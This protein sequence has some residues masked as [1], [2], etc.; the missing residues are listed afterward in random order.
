MI[1]I[2]ME[3]SFSQNFRKQFEEIQDEL[4]KDFFLIFNYIQNE[5]AKEGENTF[6]NIK[7]KYTYFPGDRILFKGTEY[8]FQKESRII[9]FYK[10]NE[11]KSL[12]KIESHFI[13]NPDY[14]KLILDKKE[15]INFIVISENTN[16]D[17]S[18]VS[19]DDYSS[20][21]YDEKVK[22]ILIYSISNILT[23]E[24][25]NKK[26][27]KNFTFDEIKIRDLSLNAKKYF[28]S[29]YQNIYVKSR[30][31]I[32]YIKELSKYVET[33]SFR[34]ISYL[35]GPKGCSKSTILLTFIQDFIK[36]KKNWGSMYF[37]IKTL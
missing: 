26:T 3:E 35:L 18:N 4:E 15:A 36:R 10:K 1:E 19:I 14:F 25:F 34:G 29:T 17:D 32:K 21:F 27:I 23:Q 5:F 24:N 13:I 20:A 11:D 33:N 8:T 9:N 28:P 6:S 37:N 7:F 2:D 16:L 12:E 30:N 31:Y 22:N